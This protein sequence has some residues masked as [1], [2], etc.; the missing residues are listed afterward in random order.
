MP[1]SN[2]QSKS[3]SIEQSTKVEDINSTTETT[4]SHTMNLLHQNTLASHGHQVHFPSSSPAQQENMVN[5]ANMELTMPA[6]SSSEA[7]QPQPQNIQYQPHSVQYQQINTTHNHP[8]HPPME[9]SQDYHLSSEQ[10]LASLEPNDEAHDANSVYADSWRNSV[11]G[12]LSY[13][14][15]PAGHA[16]PSAAHSQPSSSSHP[17]T[18]QAAVE[19]AHY[20]ES[21][22]PSEATAASA[23]NTNAGSTSTTD[24]PEPPA[25]PA[26]DVQVPVSFEDQVSVLLQE[27]GSTQ[28][29]GLIKN[30]GD[31]LTYKQAV[32]KAKIGNKRTKY[33][34][35]KCDDYPVDEAGQIQVR[36]RLFEAIVNLGGVQDKVSDD[37]DFLGSLAVKKVRSLSPVEV[38]LVVNELMEAM[39]NVQLGSPVVPAGGK[40]LQ[41][42]SFGAKVDAVV[43]ALSLNKAVCKSAIESGDYL[44]RVAAHPAEERRRKNANLANNLKKG[45]IL[46]EASQKDGT[47]RKGKGKE[48]RPAEDEPEAEAEVEAGRGSEVE[49]AAVADLESR[50]PAKRQRTSYKSAKQAQPPQPA[51]AS[52]QSSSLPHP[53]AL[54]PH[55]SATNDPDSTRPQ[56]QDD[57]SQDQATEQDSG[58]HVDP[59]LV[60]DYQDIFGHEV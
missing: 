41:A 52:P 13:Q 60:E 23:D 34:G 49:G 5:F 26:A 30:G 57:Q 10:E 46:R 2:G 25:Q 22:S 37:G 38:E 53:R 24:A 29:G 16:I 12:D 59:E 27:V 40:V 47:A 4:T 36:R 20:E 18:S 42:P 6:H 58:Q 44:A 17:N 43:A 15:A 7:H 19:A 32:W 50:R 11:P 3:A 8:D 28:Y 9:S 35:R 39:R 21:D 56:Q 33:L 51:Q 48:K 1:A 14:P 55:E 31:A 54:N 45:N